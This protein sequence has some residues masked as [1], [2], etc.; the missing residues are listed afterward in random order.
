MKN[1][2]ISIESLDPEMGFDVSRTS[3]EN[4]STSASVQPLLEIVEADILDVSVAETAIGIARLA[5]GDEVDLTIPYRG[6][7]PN[8]IA[9]VSLDNL[10]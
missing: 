1:V 6:I 9:H 5:K 4:S 3:S 7:P 10:D 2:V 8:E